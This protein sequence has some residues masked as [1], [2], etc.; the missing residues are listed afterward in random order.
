VFAEGRHKEGCCLRTKKIFLCGLVL[1]LATFPLVT[2]VLAASE[3]HGEVKFG[4]LPIPGATIT[5]TQGDKKLVTISDSQGMY[6]FPDLPDGV[7]TFE[8]EMLCFVP[9][10]QDVTVGSDAAIPDWE[11]KLLPLE[12][13]KAQAGPQQAPVSVAINAP[14][15]PAAESA[16]AKKSKKTAIAPANTPGGFQRADV[17]ASKSDAA[18]QSNATAAAA[19]ENT[20]SNDD[21]S[22]RAA[23]GLLINGTANNG[24]SSPFATNPAFGNNRNGLRSLYT[25]SIG[26]KLDNSALDAQQFSTTGQ[27]TPK[28]SYN[29][30]TGLATFGGPIRI[31]RMMPNGPFVFL[32]YQ[33][34]RN[35]TV[36]TTP[37]T[38]PTLAE[39][40]GDFSL[41]GTP[42]VD[43]LNGV[44]FPGNIIPV[45]RISPQALSL[46]SFRS[47][48]RR[49]GKECPVL[50]RSRWSPYH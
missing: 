13:I 33:W 10:K 30:F 5:A 42:I 35:R 48:E 8:I 12:E 46:L 3:H 27:Q 26:F 20:S 32:A 41:V 37:G 36:N 40:A 7:W 25:G 28:P 50:C 15:T 45:N 6:S 19:T 38:M 14:A 17:N 43:P 34:L 23:D 2:A 16:P 29:Q 44:A 21:L 24:A 22:K 31:P 11:L 47:E 49:V 4:G 9:V 18:T 39:R 1:W